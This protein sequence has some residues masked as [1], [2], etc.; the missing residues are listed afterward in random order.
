M[1]LSVVMPV[2]NEAATIQSIV[3]RVLAAPFEIELII[4]DDGSTDATPTILK[5]VSDTVSAVT[6][7]RH[8]VNRGKGAALRTGFAA[9]T[10]DIVLVQ[11]ADLEYDPGQYPAL[12]QPLL[13]DEADVVFGSRFA[14]QHHRKRYFWHTFGNWLLTAISNRMTGLNLTDM[15]TCYKVFPRQLLERIELREDGF[16][17]EPEFTATVARLKR[18]DGSP[19]RIVEIPV[20]YDRRGFD[21]GKKIGLADAVHAIRCI[22]RYRR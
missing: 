10:G 1:L 5:T 14:G 20:S 19:L 3:D 21:E 12:L 13:D 18:E 8:P 6:V 4:V 7:L 22:W 17:F 2:Y 16:G 11:D 15:E 9:A